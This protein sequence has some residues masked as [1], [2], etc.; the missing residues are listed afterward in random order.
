MLV[1]MYRVVDFN[2]CN[3]LDLFQCQYFELQQKIFSLPFWYRNSRLFCFVFNLLSLFCTS[4]Y[5][6]LCTQLL[7]RSSK[8]TARIQVLIFKVFFYYQKSQYI[9]IMKKCFNQRLLPLTLQL[10]RLLKWPRGSFQSHSLE[11]CGLASSTFIL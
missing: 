11:G 5:S 1:Y 2:A 8:Y 3:L 6:E 7:Y 10:N 9:Y 4:S